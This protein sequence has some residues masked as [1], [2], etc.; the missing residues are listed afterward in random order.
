MLSEAKHLAVHRA[1]PFASLRVTGPTLDGPEKN[2]STAVG[3]RA[4]ERRGV[5]LYGRPLLGVLGHQ[6]RWCSI[7]DHSG[8]ETRIMRAAIK[9]PTL[10]TIP[11][12]SVGFSSRVQGQ[13]PLAGFQ[14]CPLM[15]LSPLPKGTRAKTYT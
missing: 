10:H 3:A 2:L 4:V 8:N 1:R 9:A 6:T 7:G 13:P 15:T 5:G 14:G 11:L 12:T